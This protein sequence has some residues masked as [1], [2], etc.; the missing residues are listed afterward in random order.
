MRKQLVQEVIGYN[1]PRY[2]CEILTRNYSRAFLRMS[3]LK[4]GDKYI[5]SYDTGYY[6]R[7]DRR[8]LL[9]PSKLYIIRA[10]FAINELNE[11]HLIPATRYLIEPELVFIRSGTSDDP[12]VRLMFYPD[13]NRLEFEAKIIRFMRSLLDLSIPDERDIYD[14]VKSHLD[15]GDYNGAVMYLDTKSERIGN[16]TAKAI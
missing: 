3:I 7:L 5:F 16:S 1:I 6:Q 8:K 12:R 4:D 10:V 13:S 15:M 11:N 9:T 2:I 14:T